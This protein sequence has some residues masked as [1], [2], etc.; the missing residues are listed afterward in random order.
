MIG[1][2]NLGESGKPDGGVFVPGPDTVFVPTAAIVVDI[3]SPGDE[4]WDKLG[5][6]AAH[7]V[8]ELLIV[9]PAARAVHWLGLQ[10]AGDYRPVERSGL[11]ELGAAKLAERLDWPE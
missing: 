1:I 5:F 3:V 7:E 4:A 2:F 9:D 8:D 11:V 10:A 6:Y